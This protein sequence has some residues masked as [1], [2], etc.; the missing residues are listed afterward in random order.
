MNEDMEEEKIKDHAREAPVEA[1]ENQADEKPLEQMTKEELV[2][3]VRELQEKANQNYEL[4]LRALAEVENIKKRTAKD[5]EEWVKYANENLIKSIL[6]AVDNL[7]NA[8]SHARDQ[9]A[10]QALREGLELTLKGMKDSLGKSGVQEIK[11]QGV[12]FDPRYHEAVY[13]VEDDRAPAGTVIQEL[14]KGYSFNGRL[15]RPAMVVV[16]KGGADEVEQREEI[17]QKGSL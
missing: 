9:N 5:R 12:A 2:A 7:E 6:P 17:P 1:Q 4:Y 16:S 8:V 10:F 14:Q 15:I 11:A 3:S 13:Q